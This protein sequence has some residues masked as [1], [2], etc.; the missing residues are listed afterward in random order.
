MRADRLTDPVAYQG[1]DWCGRPRWGGL[2]WVDM[3]AGDIL[4]LTVGGSP[5]ATSAAIAAAQ[6]LVQF[7]GMFAEYERY[8]ELGIALVMPTARLCRPDSW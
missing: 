2:R 8:A 3:R 7:Q 1:R 5:G 4:A 6:L